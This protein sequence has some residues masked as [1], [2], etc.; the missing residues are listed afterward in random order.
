MICEGNRY[1]DVNKCGI[2]WHGD[3]ERKKVV[4]I[5]LGASIPLKYQWFYKSK[6]FGEIQE[7][8]LDHGDMYIMS[9]KATG[10]DWK[11]RS[12]KTL[13]HCAGCNKY[14]KPK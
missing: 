11:L 2:G 14:T 9:E 3:A 8:V 4:A 13:R 12:K 1:F 7:F 10:H 6:S 5:R